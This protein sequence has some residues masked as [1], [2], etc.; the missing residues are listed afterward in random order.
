MGEGGAAQHDRRRD[1][2]D[3]DDGNRAPT[4]EQDDGAEAEEEAPGG[5]DGGRLVRQALDQGGGGRR[6]GRRSRDFGGGQVEIE[7]E[8]VGSAL[9]RHRDEEIVM[10]RLLEPGRRKPVGAVGLDLGLPASVRRREGEGGVR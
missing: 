1:R 3:D 5:G 7:G 9:R 10:L 2:Q 8:D 4:P 6:L